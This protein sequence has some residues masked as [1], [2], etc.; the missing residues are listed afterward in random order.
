MSL[1]ILRQFFQALTESSRGKDL[2]RGKGELLVDLNRHAEA[3]KVQE[4][5][6]KARAEGS[7][8]EPQLL[9]DFTVLDFMEF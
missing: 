2:I 3:E 6:L 5:L 9:K 7:V 1:E 4:A 8:K